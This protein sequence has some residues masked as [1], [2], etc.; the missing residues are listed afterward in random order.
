MKTIDEL[1]KEL[2]EIKPKT[3]EAWKKYQIKIV[4]AQPYQ[5]AWYKLYVKTNELIS[6]IKTLAD[7]KL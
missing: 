7:E 5:D 1:V 2:D 4:E 3:D 6:T